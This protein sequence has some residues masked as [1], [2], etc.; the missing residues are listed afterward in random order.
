[1]PG[2]LQDKSFRSELNQSQLFAEHWALNYTHE[3]CEPFHGEYF[4]R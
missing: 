1:M 4:F 2:I 3:C